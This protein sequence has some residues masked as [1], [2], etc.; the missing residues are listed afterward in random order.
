[1]YIWI[2]LATIMI[3]LSFFN[4]SP[5]PDKENAYTEVKASTAVTRF[6][7]ENMAMTRFMQCEVLLGLHTNDWDSGSSPFQVTMDS[8]FQYSVNGENITVAP[9]DSLPIGYN[10]SAADVSAQ[11]YLYCMDSPLEQSGSA[12][13]EECHFGSDIFPTYM[14]SFAPIPNRWLSKDGNNT[15]LPVFLKYLSDETKFSGVAGYTKCNGT[16]C[17]LIGVA[18]H[19][20]V[21]YLE[22]PEDQTVP[23]KVE[24]GQIAKNSPIWANPQFNSMCGA[25]NK[26]CMFMYR[27]M[28]TTDE[29]AY[30]R[31]LLMPETTIPET[32]ATE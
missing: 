9:Q 26:P 8:R 15:P 17:E 6:K 4:L 30:C 13:A 22:N 21:V 23:T 10:A 32:N 18:S 2:L 16:T 11:H 3:G 31:N 7:L 24:T 27:K 12:I 28:P 29:K 1:M 20:A 14:I 25:V 19:R 5:R